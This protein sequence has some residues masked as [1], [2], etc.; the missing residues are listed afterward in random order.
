MI[1]VDTHEYL[2]NRLE[3]PRA[4]CESLLKCMNRCSILAFRLYDVASYIT[5]KK[6]GRWDSVT[7]A[8]W[9]KQKIGIKDD[10][11]FFE[12]AIGIKP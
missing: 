1:L 6:K 2:N 10:T 3:H 11:F 7:D 4:I 8:E 5:Q 12:K 9:I